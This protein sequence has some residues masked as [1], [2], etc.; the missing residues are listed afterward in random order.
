MANSSDDHRHRKGV[1]ADAMQCA[2]C[3]LLPMISTFGSFT[4]CAKRTRASPSALAH[5][6]KWPS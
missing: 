3:K 1:A 2:T 4:C 6:S 5:C